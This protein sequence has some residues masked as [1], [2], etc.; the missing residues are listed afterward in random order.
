MDETISIIVPTYN[1]EEF[2]NECLDSVL[3]QRFEGCELVV[4]DDGSTDRTRERL[5]SCGGM[6]NVKMAFC[7]HRGASS[8]RNAGLEMA[9]GKYVCFLD[10]DDCIHEDFLGKT[11]GLLTK[12]ADLYIFGIERIF[13]D[14]SSEIWGVNDDEYTSV[15]DFADEYIRVGRMLIYSNCNKLYRKSII[16]RA[17]IRFDEELFFGE[18]RLF[19]FAYLRACESLSKGTVVTSA[20]LML[21][22]IQRRPQSMSNRFIPEYDKLLMQLHRAKA[23]CFLTLSRGTSREEKETFERNDLANTMRNIRDYKAAFGEI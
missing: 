11:Q 19:N 14:G 15:S 12:D 8:A 17:D 23:D 7:D 3:S 20:L 10:C 16:E 1:C 6:E 21:K 9:S 5:E 18:D 22:Y 13:I 4:V 2:V